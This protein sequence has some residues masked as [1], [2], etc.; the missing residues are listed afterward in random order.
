M[1]KQPQ[2]CHALATIPEC[3]RTFDNV[4]LVVNVAHQERKAG[5]YIANERF[6][7]YFGICLD[8]IMVGQAPRGDRRQ[9]PQTPE[10]GTLEVDT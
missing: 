10:E 4:S 7:G 6:D 5:A 1:P 2:L 8:R 3:R 9:L